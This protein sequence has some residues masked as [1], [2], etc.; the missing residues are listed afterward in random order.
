MNLV[1]Y[2]WESLLGWTHPA[3]QDGHRSIDCVSLVNALYQ[4]RSGIDKWGRVLR[5][6][7]IGRHQLRVGDLA[8][9][10]GWR[11]GALR[12]RHVAF[13]IRP[14]NILLHSG[15]CGATRAWTDWMGVG[16]F[17][18]EWLRSDFQKEAEP[19]ILLR[20]DGGT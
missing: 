4:H 8:T 14:P 5:S 3:Y 9:W 15:H 1:T 10:W 2:P 7:Q 19:L 13:V 12:P 16:L 17:D 18:C 20:P 11:D 6:I